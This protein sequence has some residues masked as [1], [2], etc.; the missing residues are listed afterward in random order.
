MRLTSILLKFRP[1]WHGKIPKFPGNISS[2]KSRYVP[3]VRRGDRMRLL[4]EL[5][6]TEKIMHILSRPYI[7]KEQESLYLQSVGKTKPDYYDDFLWQRTKKPIGHRYAYYH[8]ISID[9][10]SNFEDED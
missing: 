4:W 1:E 3:A 10:G 8:L 7:T 2:G 5:S 9:K 6:E